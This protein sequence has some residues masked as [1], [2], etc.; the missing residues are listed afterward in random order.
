MVSRFEKA[1]SSICERI[2]RLENATPSGALEL[3][4][5]IGM[6]AAQV[7][8]LREQAMRQISEFSTLTE[9]C[10]HFSHKK[11][12][13]PK[14]P[15]ES[16]FSVSITGLGHIPIS[17]RDGEILACEKCTDKREECV[18][19]WTGT[20]F[21]SLMDFV[22]DKKTKESLVGSGLSKIPPLSI[23]SVWS[24]ALNLHY[25]RVWRTPA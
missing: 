11:A 8:V 7:M 23:Q 18:F 5:S 10:N 3:Q 14:K 25:D 20:S 13:Y 6:Y 9:G 16:R 2:T 22:D 15:L 1:Y 17:I 24:S 12:F 4:D 21:S 19:Y